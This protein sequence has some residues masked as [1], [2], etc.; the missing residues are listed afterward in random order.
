MAI[1]KVDLDLDEIDL[2]EL[3]DHIEEQ[4]YTV[5]TNDDVEELS[6][7]EDVD[8]HANQIAEK[9]LGKQDPMGAI[10]AFCREYGNRII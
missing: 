6:D 10:Q 7:R 1:V 5:M 2:D 3:I 9:I 8:Y 4:G